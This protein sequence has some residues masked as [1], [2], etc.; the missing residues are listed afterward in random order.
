ME[1]HCASS[2]SSKLDRQTLCAAQQHVRFL[3]LVW[4]VLRC[5]TLRAYRCCR[6]SVTFSVGGALTE[7]LSHALGVQTVCLTWGVSYSSYLTP[8]LFEVVD[9]WVLRLSQYILKLQT[10]YR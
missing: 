10:R 4:V 2:W 8:V 7:S 6:L 5:E 9:P 3:V 1:S